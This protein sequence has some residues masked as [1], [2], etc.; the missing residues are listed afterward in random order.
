[1]G[2]SIGF[3]MRGWEIF[4]V[5]LYSWKR[6]ANHAI[7]WRPS[8]LPTPFF[9]TPSPTYILSTPSRTFLSPP[10]PTSTALSVIMFLWLNRWSCHICCTILLNANMDLYMSRLG[11]LVQ[12]GLWFG[13]VQQGVNFTKVTDNVVFYWYSDLI[14]HTNKHP[15]TRST[16]RG[17]KTNTPI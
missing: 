12:A 1:M 17:Q 16:L 3:I 5:S 9:S 11:T 6:G 2:G 10:A 4:K 14:S 13:F 7:L 15:G 8:I